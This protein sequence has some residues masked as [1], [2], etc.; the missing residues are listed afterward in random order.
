MN[1]KSG[2]G[3]RTVVDLPAR[4]GENVRG[5]WS[6]SVLAGMVPAPKAPTGPTETLTIP[7]SSVPLPTRT[8]RG[9]LLGGNAFAPN[10]YAAI[11]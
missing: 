4:K 8:G 1:K 9:G 3:K 2:N 11:P 6:V 5:G 10:G 7:L